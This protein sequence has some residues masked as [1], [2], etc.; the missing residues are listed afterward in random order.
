MAEVQNHMAQLVTSFRNLRLS[1]V[2][3]LMSLIILN[4]YKGQW[5]GNLTHLRE[6]W[7]RRGVLIDLR[8]IGF[9]RI[10]PRC[11][12]V[13]INRTIVTPALNLMPIFMLSVQRSIE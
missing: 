4:D 11:P 1:K 13:H 8:T 10:G 6:I 9:K 12:F 7:E 2:L 3:N 5:W